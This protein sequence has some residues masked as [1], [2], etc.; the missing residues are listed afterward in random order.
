MSLLSNE[1]VGVGI[2]FQIITIEVENI[3]LFESPKE[4]GR[5]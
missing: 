2:Y 4:K 3:S 5:I 1:R